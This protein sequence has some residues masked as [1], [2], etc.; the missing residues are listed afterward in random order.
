MVKA[1][2]F[3]SFW[4]WTVQYAREYASS[5]PLALGW[6]NFIRTFGKIISAQLPFWLL[7]GAGA[8]FLCTKPG[9]RT[10]RLFVSGFILVSFLSILPG[11]VFREHY[12]VLL[13][14]AVALLSGAAISSAGLLLSQVRSARFIPYFLIM[15][16]T[17]YSLYQ[18]KIF[19]TLTPQEVSR[20]TS[21]LNPFPEALQIAEYIKKHT[22]RDE[23]IAVLG[24]E[25]EIFFYADRLSASGHIYMYGLMENQPYAGRMQMQM[26]REIEAARPK[27]VV[28]VNVPTSWKVRKTSITSVFSWADSYV[29]N[30]YE[31]VGVID[32]LDATTTRYLWDDRVT[33]YTPLSRAFVSVYKRKE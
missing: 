14:P 5:P 31:Q 32:I 20:A 13:L 4:F 22:T 12:F 23:P 29:Q 15:A 27:F 2:S 28:Y 9:C 11:L 26:I 16:A 25:P 30:L 24:S 17:V 10:D 19:F 8:F 7:A 1:G 3:A 21:G 33:G 18:E 6:L